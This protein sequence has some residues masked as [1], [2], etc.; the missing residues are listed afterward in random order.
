MTFKNFSAAYLIFTLVFVLSGC[1]T[2][3]VTVPEYH[4]EY[5]CK[6]DSFVKKDSVY[7]KDSIFIVQKGDTIYYNKVTYRDRYRDV[8]KFKTD[9]ILRADSIRIPYPAVKE[10][11][12]NEQR[13]MNIGKCVV[14][15]IKGL[16]IIAIA[17]SVLIWWYR[18]KRC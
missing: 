2:K 18:N 7:L 4:T 12:K 3:Y 1:K 8:Y 5:I 16:A 9:T 10:L 14:A 11:S 15:L 6:T 13:L 17:G